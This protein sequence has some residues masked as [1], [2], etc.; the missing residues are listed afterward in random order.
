MTTASPTT[1]VNAR[2]PALRCPLPRRGG[3]ERWRPPR[4]QER[5]ADINGGDMNGF[6]GQAAG[7]SRSCAEPNNPACTN[8]PADVMGYHDAREIPNYWAYANDFVLQDHMFE[9]TASWSLPLAPVHWSR[10]G[11]PGA[12]PDDR[13]SCVNAI[14]GAR[15]AGLRPPPTRASA[16]RSTPGPT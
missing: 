9:P 8:A 5:R 12:R 7:G 3:R 1:C 14:D 2:D 15:H 16:H 6:V 4:Q 13:S 10:T 11:R